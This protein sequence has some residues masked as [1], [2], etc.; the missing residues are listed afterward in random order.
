MNW[1]AEVNKL[2]LLCFNERMMNINYN[3]YYN[4]MWLRDIIII[5]V[6]CRLRFLRSAIYFFNQTTLIFFHHQNT[7]FSCKKYVPIQFYCNG[8][9]SR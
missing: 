4:T 1:H 2:I 5:D 6:Y 7:I 3:L 9:L 8:H